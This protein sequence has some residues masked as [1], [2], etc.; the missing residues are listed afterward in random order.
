MTPLP[1]D[2]QPQHPAQPPAQASQPPAGTGEPTARASEPPGEPSQPAEASQPPSEPSPSPAAPS[3]PLATR[4]W[5]WLED[6]EDLG[7]CLT[8]E[9][10]AELAREGWDLAE[11]DWYADDP[12]CGPPELPAREWA[13]IQADDDRRSGPVAEAFDAG[14][15]RLPGGRSGSGFAAGGPLDVMLPGSELAWHARRD[16]AGLDDG[17]PFPPSAAATTAPNKPPAG[18]STNPAQG[19]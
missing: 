17:Q 12:D 5:W 4:S 19:L 18:T 3:Q 16:L 8:I 13:R 7:D 6:G 10:A 9:Q 15:N 1:D 2:H 11:A 14:F